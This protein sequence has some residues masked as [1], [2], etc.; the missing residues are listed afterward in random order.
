MPIAHCWQDLSKN[1]R[2]PEC[3]QWEST[4]SSQ[5]RAD[6]GKVTTRVK[7]RFFTLRWTR[8]RSG[9]YRIPWLMLRRSLG[10]LLTAW[11]EKEYRRQWLALALAL[12]SACLVLWYTVI[13]P[14]LQP[15]AP[16]SHIH[17]PQSKQTGPGG[18]LRFSLEFSFC[19]PTTYNPLSLNSSPPP[20]SLSVALTAR[21]LIASA[22][23][24]SRF[25]VCRRG[26]VFVCSV[27]CDR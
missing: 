20:S 8:R 22:S 17:R 16:C 19:F 26:R 18:L 3:G 21:T 11:P 6:S 9:L 23:G 10:T 12:R 5:G 24:E 27:L 1:T 13:R 15:T 7:V 25:G 4:K 14:S 2:R